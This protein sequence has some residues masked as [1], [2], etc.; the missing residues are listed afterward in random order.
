MVIMFVSFAIRGSQIAEILNDHRPEEEG[1]LPAGCPVGSG[2]TGTPPL[3]RRSL[4]VS[5]IKKSEGLK[6]NIPED[7]EVV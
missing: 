3:S 5:E 4:R 1:A 6:N 2:S 7:E